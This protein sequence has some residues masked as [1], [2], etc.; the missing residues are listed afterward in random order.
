M[1]SKI[2]NTKD[3]INWWL[4]KYH[5]T[6]LDEVLELYP[7]WKEKPQDY[8]RDF[9]ETFA[10]TQEQHD[11]WLKWAKDYTK[12]VTG[13][14][15]RLFDRSW[16]FLY[17]DTS[18]Q[19]K[20]QSTKTNK[21]NKTNKV[22][23]AKILKDVENGKPLKDIARENNILKS[24]GHANTNKLKAIL[25]NIKQPVISLSTTDK[26]N[27]PVDVVI[28]FDT[29]GS[30]DSYLKAVKRKSVEFINDIFNNV[31]NVQIGICAFGDY[32]DPISTRFQYSNLSTSKEKLTTF[33]EES[34]NTSG[35]DTNEFYEYVIKRVTNETTWRKDSNRIFILIGDSNPHELGYSYR[36]VIKNNTIDWREEVK[37]AAKKGI[38]LHTLRI[39]EGS[40]YLWYSEAA[41]ITNGM[42][43]KFD[44]NIH[45]AELLKGLIYAN[46]NEEAYQKEYNNAM[47]SGDKQLID[48]YTQIEEKRTKTDIAK[49]IS[50]C[51]KGTEM[52]VCFNKQ[53]NKDYVEK[54]I[55]N[56]LNSTYGDYIDIRTDDFNTKELAK[57]VVEG[58]LHTLQGKY[59]GTKDEF[60]RYYFTDNSIKKGYNKR[61]VDPRTIKYV[62]I[63]NKKYIRK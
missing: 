25:K 18:P 55:R 27:P 40:R 50:E 20:Q 8:N 59:L 16:G 41:E 53:I 19:I 47:K 6:N 5:N 34:K 32:C 39:H 7:H 54:L 45:T 13:I 56:Y 48:T 36:N 43:I 51:E 3:L 62:V 22:D 14:K 38:T 2:V 28:A 46:T 44:S 42:C 24:N 10:V 58:E 29:T 15:G 61:L 17:L 60:G 33:I 57:L 35:G 49:I 31:P 12:R 30:M 23:I 21:M 9:Y 1:T 37:R 4:T 11:E 26:H 63:D 52:E